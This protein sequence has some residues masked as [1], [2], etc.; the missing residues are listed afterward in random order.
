[1]S[2][3]DAASSRCTLTPPTSL[4]G[5]HDAY[6]P[7]ES[8]TAGRAD[9]TV[10]VWMRLSS[11]AGFT[12]A[13]KNQAQRRADLQ[14]QQ[15]GPGRGGRLQVSSTKAAVAVY[16][17]RVHSGAAR[18]AKPQEA[19]SSSMGTAPPP[20]DG[21]PK[22]STVT[23]VQLLQLG[24]PFGANMHV[25][26]GTPTHPHEF[27]SQ[28]QAPFTH[29]PSGGGSS[30]PSPSKQPRGAHTVGWLLP[31]SAPSPRSSSQHLASSA[32][33][34]PAPTVAGGSNSGGSKARGRDGAQ[35][36]T[37][38]TA[39]AVEL[40]RL[41]QVS[42]EV[43][44][45]STVL[46]VRAAA[47][48]SEENEEDEEGEGPQETGTGGEGEEAGAEHLGLPGGGAGGADG[49]AAGAGRVDYGAWVG[50]IRDMMEDLRQGMEQVG[51]GGLMVWSTNPDT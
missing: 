29:S 23:H 44:R 28:Q 16:G 43:L 15:R 41:R 31:E 21:V 3:T 46:L 8:G 13:Y 40:H 4:Q 35:A 20:Y 27:A 47:E 7:H 32:V 36:G 34:T 5:A 51:L 1:M 17:G 37:K 50:S 18:G 25:S 9:Q 24:L 42:V 30:S 39:A 6:A 14:Q 11:E 10:P 22:R 2:T 48:P 12:A 19:A 45:R 33:A 49:V 26:P 38:P